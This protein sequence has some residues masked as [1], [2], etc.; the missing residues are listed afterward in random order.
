MSGAQVSLRSEGARAQDVQEAVLFN[1]DNSP[2]ALCRCWRAGVEESEAEAEMRKGE[3]RKW[4]NL[5]SNGQQSVQW[6]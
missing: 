3:C 5:L 2:R 6:R 4:S 1:S